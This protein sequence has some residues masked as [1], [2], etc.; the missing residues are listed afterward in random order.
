[1]A[2]SHFRFPLLAEKLLGL[3]KVKV[4]EETVPNLPP[5]PAPTHTLCYIYEQCDVLPNTR[6][7]LPP[8]PASPK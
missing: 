5:L 4:F 3:L 1:M 7:I 8:Q 6:P 2:H